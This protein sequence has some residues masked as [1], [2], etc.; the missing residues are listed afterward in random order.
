M[1]IKQLL[2]TFCFHYVLIYGLTMMATFFWC[3][4]CGDTEVPLA[5]FWKIMIFSL[6]AD[7]PVFVFLSKK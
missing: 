7:L 3:L 1:N 6:V 5:Y 4:A 2:K